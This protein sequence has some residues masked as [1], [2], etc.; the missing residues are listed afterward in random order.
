M[1]AT[2][3]H[4]YKE[5]KK[6]MDSMGLPAPASL[7]GTLTA[8]LGTTSAIASAI[9]KLGTTATLTEVMFTIPTAAG[10]AA[11]A[12]GV[13]EVVVAVGALAAAFYLGAC[14]GSLLAAAIDTYGLPV[15]GKL[16]AWLKAMS[17]ALNRPVGRYAFTAMMAYPEL[18]K[19]RRGVDLATQL[20]TGSRAYA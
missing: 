14:I 5:F 11:T 4:F 1:S 18:S 3:S 9:T 6:N 16:G 19:V 10:A 15:M 17:K 7:F 13:S 20:D 8:A 12:A 2:D